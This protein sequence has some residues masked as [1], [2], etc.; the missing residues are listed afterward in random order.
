MADGLEAQAQIVG[1]SAFSF[2][3]HQI[4]Q[5]D[6]QSLSKPNEAVRDTTLVASKISAGNE[7][8]LVS[9]NQLSL[10]AAQDSTHTLYDM[11]DKGNWGAKKAQRDEVMQTTQIGTEI[12][13]GGNLTL[14]SGG[15]QLYQVA[16]LNSGND[17]NLQSGGTI[18]FEGVKDLHDESH[19]KSKSN[20]AWFS[21]KGK[22]NTD[23]TLRQSE[24]LA[25]G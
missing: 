7:A 21:M 3:E 24:L 20:L 16:K 17:L 11:K 9:G 14:R 8:Y 12:R 13:T 22:G 10:V 2:S 15:D 5:T 23:E 6:V 1:R 18:T 4:I 25:Q 19:A